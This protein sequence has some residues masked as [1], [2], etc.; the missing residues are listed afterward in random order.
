ML[1]LW[2]SLGK[3]LD[4]LVDLTVFEVVLVA[5]GNSLHNTDLYGPYDCSCIDF[6]VAKV[7]L[8]RR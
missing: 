5:I 4:L 8:Y 2:L 1:Q 3:E 7:G 6:E